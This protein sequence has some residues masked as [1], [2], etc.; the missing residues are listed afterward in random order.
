MPFLK[1]Q[2]GRRCGSL[3]S[4]KR[5]LESNTKVIGRPRSRFI[6]I[7][8][9]KNGGFHD[10]IADVIMSESTIRYDNLDSPQ[11]EHYRVV[12]K[13]RYPSINLTRRKN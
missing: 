7:W 1:G 2:A 5:Q 4:D 3:A 6:I 10:V 9:L 12:Q 8:N 11:G 13:K